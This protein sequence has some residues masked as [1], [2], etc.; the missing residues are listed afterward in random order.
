MNG[1]TR[2][3]ASCDFMEWFVGLASGQTVAMLPQSEAFIQ[4]GAAARSV[5]EFN[6]RGKAAK[7][8]LALEDAARESA[9]FPKS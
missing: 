6:R 3:K 1:W 4:A 5:A 7:A 8:T 9:G 2:F